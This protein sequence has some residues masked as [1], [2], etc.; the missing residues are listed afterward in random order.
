MKAKMTLKIRD[1]LSDYQPK[2]EHFRK[3]WRSNRL[4]GEKWQIIDVRPDFDNRGF[5]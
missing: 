2:N 3:S 5:F 1:P 4:S